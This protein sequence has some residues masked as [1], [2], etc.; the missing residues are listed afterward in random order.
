MNIIQPVRELLMAWRQA[1][2]AL[3]I[4]M[5]AARIAS[6]SVERRRSGAPELDRIGQPPVLQECSQVFSMTAAD[7]HN[8]FF[9][10]SNRR[11]ASAFSASVRGSSM[12]E[13]IAWA[14]EK[15]LESDAALFAA[16][17]SGVGGFSWETTGLCGSCNAHSIFPRKCSGRVIRAVIALEA[18]QTS[19][20]SPRWPAAR[21]FPSYEASTGPRRCVKRNT[22]YRDSCRAS[23]HRPRCVATR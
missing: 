7:R 15:E 23:A 8:P 3:T 10:D 22:R 18:P 11:T 21:P 12:I 2:A 20:E 14:K 9:S 17:A 5:I 16:P 6:D 13:A 19:F 1:L 4:A